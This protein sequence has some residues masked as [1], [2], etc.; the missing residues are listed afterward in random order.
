[1]GDIAD[2]MLNGDM[3]WDGTWLGDGDGY[4]R[5][6]D[7]SPQHG[8]SSAPPHEKTK[9]RIC[10]K[11]VKKIGIKQHLNDVHGKRIERHRRWKNGKSK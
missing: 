10:G 6:P 4:P 3:A 2:A 1:M 7:G 9:C 5:N 11:W 8:Y